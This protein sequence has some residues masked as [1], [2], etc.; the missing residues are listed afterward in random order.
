MFAS[1]IHTCGGDPSQ[2]IY[3]ICGR[4]LRHIVL[5]EVV[6]TLVE[7]TQR[8]LQGEVARLDVCARRC[9]H[10]RVGEVRTVNDIAV[11]IGESH[12]VVLFRDVGKRVVG[13]IGLESCHG[14]V[15]EDGSRLRGTNPSRQDELRAVVIVAPEHAVEDSRC[16][17]RRRR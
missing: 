4:V 7:Q 13:D 15:R 9:R 10:L 16:G 17:G 2:V 3:I 8:R 11:F 1:C 6:A 14:I 5:I 12:V